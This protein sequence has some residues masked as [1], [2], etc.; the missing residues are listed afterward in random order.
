MDYWYSIAAAVVVIT[1]LKDRSATG[2]VW[3]DVCKLSAIHNNALQVL[4]II[5]YF[6][7]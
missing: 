6:I 5:L 4:H 3:R 1:G 7:L 2:V